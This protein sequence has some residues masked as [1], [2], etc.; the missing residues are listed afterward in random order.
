MPGQKRRILN[1]L[2]RKKNIIGGT[3]FGSGGFATVTGNPPVPYI[4]NQHVSNWSSKLH[5]TS[6]KTIKNADE[7]VSKIFFN[8]SDVIDVENS[9]NLLKLVCGR[10][11]KKVV[12]PYLLLPHEFPKQKIVM[13][14]DRDEYL[15]PL[16]QSDKYWSKLNGT[17]DND[18]RDKLQGATKQ[19][20]YPKATGGALSDLQITNYSE[21]IESLYNFKNIVMGIKTLHSYKIVHHDLKPL[22]IL[23]QEKKQKH[24]Y[25]ISDLD[26]LTKF[27]DFTVDNIKKQHINRL[28]HSWGYEYFPTC[29][30]LL[31][32]VLQSVDN[33]IDPES[34]DSIIYKGF[35]EEFNIYAA[36]RNGAHTK[37]ILE[38]FKTFFKSKSNADL[39]L[40]LIN[41]NKFGVTNI[42]NYELYDSRGRI[43][44]EKYIMLSK[45]NKYIADSLNSNTEISFSEKRDVLLKYV[46]IYGIGRCILELV[47]KFIEKNTAELDSD[48]IKHIESII[49]FVY[50]LLTDAYFVEK[51]YNN[52][53]LE[54]YEQN[55]I[56]G[57]SRIKSS[58]NSNSS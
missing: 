7:Y 4:P 29:I 55:V 26:T 5:K 56:Q 35:F 16:F 43:D 54:L 19:V 52:D 36:H 8:A 2:K 18:S 30:T 25:K 12:G 34:S 47:V 48:T 20:W 40:Q 57:K 46:D 37:L 9:I 21:F 38:K 50:N 22:N 11:F 44:N 3:V 23:I 41:R 6:R 51:I 28:L 32:S 13:D 1:S 39:I 14:I 49:E 24:F 15:G 33:N 17:L 27:D 45:Y 10:H 31:N 53:I 42:K 58:M